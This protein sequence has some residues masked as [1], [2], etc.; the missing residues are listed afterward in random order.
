MV[1]S[2]AGL[3][4]AKDWWLL[5]ADSDDWQLQLSSSAEYGWMRGVWGESIPELCKAAIIYWLLVSITRSKIII[6]RIFF[7]HMSLNNI[8]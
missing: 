3:G 7:P 5:M 6:T 4:E 1:L 2:W 8:K